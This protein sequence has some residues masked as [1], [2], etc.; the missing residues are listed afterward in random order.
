VDWQ[1][2]ALAVLSAVLL[3]RSPQMNSAW[4]VLGA[5]LLGVV[6]YMHPG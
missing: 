1:T 3:F 5:G 6:R 2:I 4:L